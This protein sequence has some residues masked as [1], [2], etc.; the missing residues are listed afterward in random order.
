MYCNEVCEAILR[1]LLRG[2]KSVSYRQPKFYL[3]VIIA[4]IHPNC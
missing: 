2:E 3:K 1:A 4:P